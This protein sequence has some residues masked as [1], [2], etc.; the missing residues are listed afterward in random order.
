MRDPLPHNCPATAQKN[1]LN[2]MYV[3]RLAQEFYEERGKFIDFLDYARPTAK[4]DQPIS[5]LQSKI[6]FHIALN[7][8]F[9]TVNKVA[10]L[11]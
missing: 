2:G 1:V 9:I 11:D 4:V 3:G 6:L 8:A 7:F 10:R 5:G